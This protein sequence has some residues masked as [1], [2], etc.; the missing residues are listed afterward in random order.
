MHFLIQKFTATHF[1]C[2]HFKISH[3]HDFKNL[4]SVWTHF[5]FTIL[6]LF[7]ACCL[8]RSDNNLF[9]KSGI[10][11]FG[12]IIAH[13]NELLEGKIPWIE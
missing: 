5:I 12:K 1:C 10:W 11:T 9:K 7:H 3:T 2:K 6:V 8:Y 4:V 13:Q